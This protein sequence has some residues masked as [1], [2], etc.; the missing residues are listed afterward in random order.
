MRGGAGWGALVSQGC[1][2][3]VPLG[4]QPVRLGILEARLWYSGKR[5]SQSLAYSRKSLLIRMGT[6]LGVQTPAF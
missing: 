6:S 4:W 3:L 2:Q 5:M 1:F